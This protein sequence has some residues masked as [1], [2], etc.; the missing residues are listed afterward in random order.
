MSFLERQNLRRRIED[1]GIELT[2]LASYI[3]VAE[4]GDDEKVIAELEET[5]VLA[6]DLGAPT[7]RVFPGAPTEPC[8]F[9]QVPELIEP[10]DVVDQR[11]ARRLSKVT[12]LGSWYGILPALETHDSHPTGAHIAGIASL[13]DGPVGVIW[14]LMHPWRVGESLEETYRHLAPWLSGGHGS[15]QLKDAALPE[16]LTP[17]LIGE[18][19]LPCAEFSDLLTREQYEGVVTL[20]L[21][22]A[23]YDEAP[24]FDAALESAMRWFTKHLEGVGQR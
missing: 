15:V 1:G 9:S 7:V 12:N 11:A 13:V 21:E 20:E 24:T 14:D 10:R 18:G 22:A 23:W 8:A 2:A 17:T 19:T 3:R 4:A 16:N 6:Y 5:I